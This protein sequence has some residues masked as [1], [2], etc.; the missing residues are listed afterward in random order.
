MKKLITTAGFWTFD[1]EPTTAEVDEIVNNAVG[2]MRTRDHIGLCVNARGMKTF[3]NSGE[4]SG[5]GRYF[6]RTGLKNWHQVQYTIEK[7]R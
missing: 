5:P 1:S 3:I 6:V 2:T 7:V 4:V